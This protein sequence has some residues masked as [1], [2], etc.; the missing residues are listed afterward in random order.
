MQNIKLIL[1][2]MHPEILLNPFVN[3]LSDNTTNIKS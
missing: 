1:K 2:L 3:T